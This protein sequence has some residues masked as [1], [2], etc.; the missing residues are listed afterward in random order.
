MFTG[1]LIPQMAVKA[2]AG[3]SQARSQQFRSGMQILEAFSAAFL[4]HKESWI[5]SGAA[6]PQIGA[7]G[8]DLAYLCQGRVD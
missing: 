2:G 1:W 3:C 8:R 5:G 6:G 7:A 4:S